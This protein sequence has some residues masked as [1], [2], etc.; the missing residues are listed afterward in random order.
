MSSLSGWFA[1][2][3]GFGG[4]LQQASVLTGLRCRQVCRGRRP[5]GS[6]VPG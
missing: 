5:T 2:L 4:E 1:M 6:P 3:T